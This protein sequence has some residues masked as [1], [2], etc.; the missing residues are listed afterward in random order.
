MVRADSSFPADLRPDFENVVQAVRQEELTTEELAAQLGSP[1]SRVRKVLGLLLDAG[2]LVYRADWYGKGKGFRRRW[3]FA[4]PG[5]ITLWRPHGE[6]RARRLF[7][8]RAAA[9]EASRRSMGPSSDALPVAF[10]FGPSGQ[11]G[12]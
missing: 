4:G 8:T 1:L 3:R 7:S 12:P 9:L 6:G 11:V 10:A 2:V 5:T